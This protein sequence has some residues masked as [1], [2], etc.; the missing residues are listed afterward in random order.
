MIGTSPPPDRSSGA[1]SGSGSAV[2]DRVPPPVLPLP[3]EGE[4]WCARD[5]ETGRLSDWQAYEGGQWVSFPN[6]KVLSKRLQEHGY[7]PVG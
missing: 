4:T 6:F 3:R 5:P 2:G 7:Q 1:L